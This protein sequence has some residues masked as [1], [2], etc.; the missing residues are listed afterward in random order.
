MNETLSNKNTNEHTEEF[1]TVQETAERYRT[2]NQ[3][4]YRWIS[5]KRFPKNA[6][7]RL[8]RKILINRKKLEEFES[9]EQK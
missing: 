6:V 3:M 8:G 2:N 7:L 5:E 4:I 1:L 9:Q